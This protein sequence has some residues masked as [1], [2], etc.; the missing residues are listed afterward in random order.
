MDGAFETVSIIFFQMYTIHAPVGTRNSKTLIPV[1][2]LMT[3]KQ[4]YS[5]E[6]LFEDLNSICD[7]FFFGVRILF[8]IKI[9]YYNRFIVLQ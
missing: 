7:D 8:Y 2:V 1:Y 4:Q 5:Y 6:S 3:N 9:V